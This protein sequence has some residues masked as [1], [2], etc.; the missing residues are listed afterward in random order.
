MKVNE[1]F[2]NQTPYLASNCL[3]FVPQQAGEVWDGGPAVLSGLQPLGAG[4]GFTARLLR[5]LTASLQT[6]PLPAW[7]VQ[8]GQGRINGRGITLYDSSNMYSS[9]S[10][11]TNCVFLILGRSFDRLC[12]RSIFTYAKDQEVGWISTS[13]TVRSHTIHNVLFSLTSVPT[14]FHPVI[15]F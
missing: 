8:Q 7:Q 5:Q 14:F 1:Y 9:T 2:C 15:Q 13:I 11:L 10:L 4:T 6:V 12:C 3:C